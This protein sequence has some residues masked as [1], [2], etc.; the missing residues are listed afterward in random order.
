M[1]KKT[2]IKIDVKNKKLSKSKR[3]ISIVTNLKNMISKVPPYLH[4]YN[5]VL[6]IIYPLY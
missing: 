2:K 6:T 5:I 4:G 1:K 3:R